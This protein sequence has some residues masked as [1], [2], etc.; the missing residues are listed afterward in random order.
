MPHALQI[1]AQLLNAW[2]VAY[3]WIEIGT[4]R[5]RF[6]RVAAALAVDAIQVFGSA[7]IR[8]Q[9]LIADRPGRRDPAVMLDLAEILLAQSDQSRPVKFGIPA[10]EIVRAGM[11]FLAVLVVPRFLDVVFALTD[12]GLSVPIVFLARDVATPFEKQNSLA[13]GS[14]RVCQGSP[15]GSR[16]YDDYVVMVISRHGISPDAYAHKW[17]LLD[18]P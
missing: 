9:L 15:S 3:V 11:K 18:C 5:R 13:S 12:Y 7:V 14:Q 6:G 10:N 16:P 4:A 8:L 1:V 2:L 17:T